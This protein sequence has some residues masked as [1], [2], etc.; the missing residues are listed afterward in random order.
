MHSTEQRLALVEART[1]ALARQRTQR[2]AAG[3][4]ALSGCLLLGLVLL[5]GQLGG[6]KHD[7]VS[8]SMAGSSLLADSA[9][10]YVLVALLSFAAAVIITTVCIRQ[11]QK[12][13]KNEQP[14]DKKEETP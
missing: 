11:R 4:S 13:N 2:R 1:R 5:I 14:Q 10:G 12:Q 9:G 6:L 7:V 8:G 3:L